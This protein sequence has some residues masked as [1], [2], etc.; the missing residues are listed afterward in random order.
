VDVP[1]LSLRQA[2]IEA[3][4]TGLR[5]ELFDN[6]RTDTGYGVEHVYLVWRHEPP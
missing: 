3:R 1:D 5:W 2:D 4:F 6:I